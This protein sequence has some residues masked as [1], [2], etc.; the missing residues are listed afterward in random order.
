VERSAS[1]ATARGVAAL[2][3]PEMAAGWEAESHRRF[4][5]ATIP[6]LKRRQQRL[7]ALLAEAC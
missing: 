1:E 5:P 7:I 6:G 4:M 2:A 3:D